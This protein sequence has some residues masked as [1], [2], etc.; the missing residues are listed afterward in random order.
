MIRP[1]RHTTSL[2]DLSMRYCS[3][4]FQAK[5]CIML[6]KFAAKT[7]ICIFGCLHARV[8]LCAFAPASSLTAICSA[9]M[10]PQLWGQGWGGEGRGEARTRL[11]GVLDDMACPMLH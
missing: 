11:K 9:S 7:H 4:L 6:C 1:C 5:P 8:L 3:C 10:G 2:N